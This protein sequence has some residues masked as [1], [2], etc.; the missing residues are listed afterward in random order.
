MQHG[1]GRAVG[2]EHILTWQINDTI[3]YF[4]LIC[5]YVD[6]VIIWNIT[7]VYFNKQTS[8]TLA[9]LNSI[10]IAGLFRKYNAPYVW[11]EVYKGGFK[12]LRDVVS[13]AYYK[14]HFETRR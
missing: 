7:L 10:K 9:Y 4:G 6:Y 2:V 1:I 14:R 11:R 3:Y 5:R 12:R 8:L 13:D